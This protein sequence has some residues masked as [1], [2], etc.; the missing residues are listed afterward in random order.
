[1]LKIIEMLKLGI[2]VRI[3]SECNQTWLSYAIDR[4]LF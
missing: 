3:L 4:N 1:M 2:Y